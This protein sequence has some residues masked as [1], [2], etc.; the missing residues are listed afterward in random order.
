MQFF[1]SLRYTLSTTTISCFTIAVVVPVLVWYYYLA[2][3]RGE[4]QHYWINPSDRR[5]IPERTPFLDAMA[6]AKRE[7][8]KGR[9]SKISTE[10]GCGERTP[11]SPLSPSP[12]TPARH[13]EK[14]FHKIHNFPHRNYIA[15]HP[16]QGSNK[17]RR[18]AQPRKC[19][20]I[21]F[22]KLIESFTSSIKMPAKKKS[23]KEDEE[24]KKEEKKEEEEESEEESEEEDSTDDE[25]RG[26]G[27]RKRKSSIE[28]AFEPVDFTMAD[29]PQVT[30]V[31]GRGKKL[32][33]FPTVVA[34]FEKCS[35]DDALFAHKFLFGNRGSHLK[36]KE[37]V[38]NLLEFSGYLKEVPKGYDAK[39]LDAEDDLEEVR[40]Q[41]IILKNKCSVHPFSVVLTLF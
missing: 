39:K 35:T 14:P 30:I 40:T 41:Q 27:K 1:A 7:V 23:K 4:E 20:T 17:R 8:N 37:L 33:E 19:L 38:N 24:P 5:P 32:K 18:Q 11:P 13:H 12:Q 31:K 22:S 15:I 36:K 29:K 34:S 10:A 26:R 28:A 25:D 3:E 16:T 9:P 2:R 21:P 6:D